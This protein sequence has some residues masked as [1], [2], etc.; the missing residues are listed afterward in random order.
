MYLYTLI[1]NYRFFMQ[2]SIW[3]FNPEHDMAL[4]SYSVYYMIPNRINKM[5][6]DLSILPIWYVEE[7]EKSPFILCDENNSHFFKEMQKLFPQLQSTSIL[8][9]LKGVFDS[10]FPWGWNP[11]LLYKIEHSDVSIN[12]LPNYSEIDLIRNLS[13]RNSALDILSSFYKLEPIKSTIYENGVGAIAISFNSTI[14]VNNFIQKYND[15]IFKAPWSGSGRGIRRIVSTPSNSDIGWMERVLRTQK[16]LIGE[17]Y[18][19]KV[20]DFAMEFECKSGEVEFIGYSLFETDNQGAYKCNILDSDDAIEKIV[21][22][23]IPSSDLY[24]VK[25]RL[26][27]LLQHFYASRYNGVLGVDMMICMKSDGYWLHPCVEVNLRMNMGIVAHRFYNRFISPKSKGEYFVEHYFSKG[28]ALD[29]DI[30]MKERYPLIINNSL[31]ESG[32][33]SLTVVN[34]DTQYQIYVV[35]SKKN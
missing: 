15:V 10:V 11:S 21:T 13:S 3:L 6:S 23:Y 25:E 2:K 35:I 34:S 31:I 8:Y 18:Y 33:L 30:M 16:T 4:A 28:E 9:S 5:K 19:N 29:F 12:K 7:G 20:V 22:H 1:D 26:I 32:Y 27:T 17:P 14:D 24:K